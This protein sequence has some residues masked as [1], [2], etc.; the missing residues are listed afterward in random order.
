MNCLSNL[1][2]DILIKQQAAEIAALKLQLSKY[3]ILSTNQGDEIAETQARLSGT[4][5]RVDYTEY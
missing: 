5:S 4:R 1:A 2:K 3:K